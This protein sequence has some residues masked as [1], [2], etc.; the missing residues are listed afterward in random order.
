MSK[1]SIV[2]DG[3]TELAEELD[4]VSKDIKP[5]VNEVLVETEKLMQ[6]KTSSAAEPYNGDGKKGYGEGDMY[7]AI[8]K[9][10]RV[11][12]EGN[13]ASVGTGFDLKAKGGY[14]SIFVTYG[15]PRINKD[16]KLYNA[17]RGPRTRK[18]IADLQEK[19]MQKY[20]KLGG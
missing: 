7:K 8:I 1:M 14:H 10:N 20:I 18:E 4:K 17:M 16:T 12:W 9:G 11:T 19:I 15:T 6:N 13:V 2:F 3:F 5:A